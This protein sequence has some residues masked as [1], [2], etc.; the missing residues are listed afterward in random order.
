MSN[1]ASATSAAENPL[2]SEEVVQFGLG[3]S[4][5]GILTR[6]TAPTRGGLPAIVLL[7][8]G[9][10]HRVGPNR[11]YVTIAR[12]FAQAGYTVLRFDFSGMGD[13]LP[14]ADHLPYAQS[15]PSEA[16]AAMD[17]LTDTYGVQ[18]FI[19]MGHC[20]GAGFSLLVASDDVRVAG[21]ALI[22]M[23]GGDEEWTEYDRMKKRSQEYPRYYG[24]RALLDRERWAKFVSGRADYRSIARNIF[25][26]TLWYRAKSYAFQTQQALRG[27]QEDGHAEQEALAQRYLAPIADR[28][29]F[30]LFVHSEGSTGLARIRAKFG[31]AL[32]QLTTSSAA[33]VVIIPQCDHLFT[34][35]DRQDRLC[36]V[37]LAW[38]TKRFDVAESLS[39]ERPQAAEAH[40]L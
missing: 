30:L 20:A 1:P 37:L 17:W 27:R 12:A 19:L 34:L 9:L 29:A 3:H 16:A 10:L 35:R 18:R 6:P 25:K 28:G 5:V 26:D 39:A 36:T 21:A 24:G 31:A 7:N 40:A 15:G 13:S 14:R 11:I 22:N 2:Y 32:N 8:A 33:E 23:E 38:A 4:L